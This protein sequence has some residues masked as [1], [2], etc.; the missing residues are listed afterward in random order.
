MQT[1]IK[2]VIL[3]LAV[4]LL[5]FGIVIAIWGGLAAFF[6]Q[7]AFVVLAIV[8]LAMM[9][10]APL[11][12]GNISSGQQEDRSNRWVFIAFSLIAVGSAILPAYCDRYGLLTL[13]GEGTRWLGVAFYTAGGVLRLWPVFVLGNR[14]SG[15]VAIQPDHTLETRNIYRYVRNPSYLGMFLYMVGWAL[16]FRSQVGLGLALLLWVPLGFRIRAEE[17]LLRAHFGAEYEAYCART[18]RLIPWL[19]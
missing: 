7:R 5:Q 12:K 17:R 2:V 16:V 18:P 1:P 9:L 8:T 4:A 19:W 3:G 13:G 11:S 10:V 6:A 14:F 15:L